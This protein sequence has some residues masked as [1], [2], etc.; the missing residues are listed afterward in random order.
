MELILVK[1]KYINLNVKVFLKFV[2]NNTIKKD[3]PITCRGG[4]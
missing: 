4:L 1:T 3:I 2:Y